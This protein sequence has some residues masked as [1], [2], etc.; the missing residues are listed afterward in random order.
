I[1]ICE[2]V[3]PEICKGTSVHFANLL[4]RCWDKDPEKR[5]SALEIQETIRGWRNNSDIL[6][7]FL[8]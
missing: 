4:K 6:S 1:D 7:K 2:G 5:P 3:R 8:K